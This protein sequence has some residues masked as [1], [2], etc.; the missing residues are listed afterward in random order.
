[1]AI[2]PI[3][4]SIGEHIGKKVVRISMS[5]D[6]PIITYNKKYKVYTMEFYVKNE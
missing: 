5:Y 3:K 4:K 6:E 2:K 1:M